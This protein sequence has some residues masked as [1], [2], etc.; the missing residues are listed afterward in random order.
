MLV[1]DGSFEEQIDELAAFQD[2]LAQSESKVQDTVKA[3]LEKD[4]RRATVAEVVRNVSALAAQQNEKEYEASY[5]LLIHVVLSDNGDAADVVQQLAG[6]LVASAAERPGGAALALTILSTLIDNSPVASRPTSYSKVLDLVAAQPQTYDVARHRFRTLSATLKS[7]QATPAQQQAI[8]TRVADLTEQQDGASEGESAADYLVKAVQVGESTSADL[9]GRAINALVNEEERYTFEPL[10]VAPGFQAV[11]SQLGDHAKLLDVLATSTYS[12]GKQTL[13]GLSS[14]LQ[15]NKIDTALVERKLRLLT[16]ATIASQ[17][18]SRR[19]RYS[20]VAESLEVPEGEVEQWLIDAIQAGLV[21]GKLSQLS[22]TFVV[23]RALQRSFES[24]QWNEVEAK[25][26]SLRESLVGVLAVV[27]N[28]KADVN[29]VQLSNG[30]EGI[31]GEDEGLA[32][33][34]DGDANSDLG[35]IDEDAD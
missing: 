10:L 32:A 7:W 34:R 31:D 3:A 17:S 23:H 27:D 28:V 35:S 19:L 13:A 26:Q 24:E 25:L 12:Q 15:T 1:V 29:G 20:T 16:V 18:D 9:A 33:G 30:L 21:E 8:Y 14:F 6:D 22:Q 2:S 5:N 4:D 11:R